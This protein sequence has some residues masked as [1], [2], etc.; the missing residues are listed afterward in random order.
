MDHMMKYSNRKKI[1]LVS[2]TWSHDL[3]HFRLL[4]ASIENSPLRDIE[5]HIAV[6]S[7]D[8]EKFLY[9]GEN[10][11][12]TLYS[13]SELL[14]S[15]IEKQR[16]KARK[17]EELFGRNL[18]RIFGSFCRTF[19][20]PKWP[21]YTGWHTQQILKLALA[22]KLNFDRII[23]IDSD[24]IIT[25]NSKLADY[26]QSETLPCFA[27]WA[28]YES[29]SGKV[30]NWVDQSSSLTKT[31]I[32]EQS[33]VNTYFD[34]PFILDS[35]ALRSMLTWLEGEFGVSWMSTL[36]SSP[37]RRLSEFG[38]YK[39]F[40]QHK[41]AS[42]INWINPNKTTKAI[43][44]YLDT[45]HILRLYH[46]TNMSALCIHSSSKRGFSQQESKLREYLNNHLFT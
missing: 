42:N 2:T 40:L 44:H 30:K 11:N 35:D 36:L 16:V 15:H 21:R 10:Q 19:G 3:E 26:A 33:V 28:P 7:E 6:Q 9:F 22:T 13:S 18:A 8:M 4:R 1:A 37:P 32:G 25:K 39:F 41:T 45:S 31:K 5:H 23:I 24:V 38:V 46:D 20:H 12:V 14:P 17:N 34:T 27:T 43:Y 29:L